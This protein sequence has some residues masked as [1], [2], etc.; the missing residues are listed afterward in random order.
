M[1]QIL[2]LCIR[3]WYQVAQEEHPGL[4]CAVLAEALDASCVTA[5]IPAVLGLHPQA[6]LPF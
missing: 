1:E 3:N 5:M 4:L 2:S 6:G